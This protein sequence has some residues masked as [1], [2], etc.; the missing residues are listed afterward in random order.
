M[1][2]ASRDEWVDQGMWR[3]VQHGNAG[4]TPTVESL[5]LIDGCR[6]RQAVRNKKDICT[7]KISRA[8]FKS[9]YVP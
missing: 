8:E 5:K 9:C 6:G 1:D 4:V 3:S 2:G 7:S